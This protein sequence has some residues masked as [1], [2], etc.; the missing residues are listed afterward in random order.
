MI[1]ST[2]P[3]DL[4][5]GLDRMAL[6]AVLTEF[7]FMDIAVAIRA[8][9]EWNAPELL[10]LLPVLNRCPMASRTIH[11]GMLAKQG[12]PGPVMVEFWS[13]PELPEIMTGCTIGWKGRLVVVGMAGEALPFQ[14]QV[15]GRFC[16]DPGIR[17]E[18]ALMAVPAIYLPMRFQQC[19]TGDRM[20]ELIRI[21]PDHLE[22][23]AMMV[24]VA[25]GAGL[26]P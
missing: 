2:D 11:R 13:G 5:K 15:S 9:P 21:K 4:V 10:H 1:K 12:K 7:I 24:A 6:G 3:P 18:F 14:S 8:L 23:P 26:P 20:V 22:I 16:L 19:I 25:F 17:Y